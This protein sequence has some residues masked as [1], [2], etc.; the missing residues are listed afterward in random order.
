M[1]KLFKDNIVDNVIMINVAQKAQA[2]IKT[3]VAKGEYL[4]GSTGDSEYSTAP[5]PIPY[6]LFL[7]KFGKSLLK[8]EGYEKNIYHKRKGQKKLTTTAK[9]DEFSI[10]KSQSGKTMVL[11]TGGYKRYREMSNKSTS[12]VTMHWTSRMMKNLGILRAEHTEAE[13]GFPSEEER[14]KAYY[15]HVGAGKNKI[16]RKFMGLTDNEW[17]S[18]AECAEKLIIQNLIK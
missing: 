1:E 3:R 6:G 12:P 13:L 11:I 5:M 7:K 18:L 8:K 2:F 15:Q 17:N 14:K 9:S 4:E 16:T 10:F